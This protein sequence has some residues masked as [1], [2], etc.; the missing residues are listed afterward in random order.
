MLPLRLPPR[1]YETLNELA[2]AT[3]LNASQVATLVIRTAATDWRA[4]KATRLVLALRAAASSP[5]ALEPKSIRTSFN[6][7]PRTTADLA[8]LAAAHGLSNASTLAVMLD[9]IAKAYGG[10]GGGQKPRGDGDMDLGALVYII[11]T[12]PPSPSP[13]QGSE[14]VLGARG[15]GG[16]LSAA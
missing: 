14:V 13:T 11:S 15:V 6:L 7:T 4:A 8:E 2:L 9:A 3:G 16:N 1:S 5:T 10:G 12:V